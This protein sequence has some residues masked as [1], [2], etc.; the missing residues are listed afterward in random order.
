MGL[1]M[2][3]YFVAAGAKVLVRGWREAELQRVVAEL[4]ENA[5][6][7]VYDVA[8]NQGADGLLQAAV[9]WFGTFTTLTTTV[10]KASAKTPTNSPTASSTRWSGRRSPAPSSSAGQRAPRRH[11]ADGGSILLTVSALGGQP[12]R[13]RT[14]PRN[15]ATSGWCAASRGTGPSIRV[16]S[17]A[18]SGL[19]RYA[20][21]GARPR[22][23]GTRATLP[24][25]D[26]PPGNG[27]AGGYRYGRRLSGVAGAALRHQRGVT[28]GR[29]R[30]DGAVIRRSAWRIAMPAR[31]ACSYR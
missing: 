19:D 18:P 12:C 25:P 7:Q 21:A 14:R 9:N 13:S 10:A 17:I 11:A 15:P 1:G 26:A 31:A 23:S 27:A 5:T 6:Y 3:R 22:R 30:Y 16:N 4:G 8:D 2:A 29:R 28:G 24:R 20:N